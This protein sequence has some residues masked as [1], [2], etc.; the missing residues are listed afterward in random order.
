MNNDPYYED[1]N[2]FSLKKTFKKATKA[3][4]KYTPTGVVVST[5]QKVAKN[6]K[7]LVSAVKKYTPTGQVVK[8][9]SKVVNKKNITKAI[10]AGS[11]AG[12]AVGKG[13]KVVGKTAVKVAKKIGESAGMVLLAP[14]KPLKEGM[15]KVLKQ[16]GEMTSG[17]LLDVAQRFYKKVIKPQGGKNNNFDDLDDNFLEKDPLF[18]IPAYQY[19]FESCQYSN[20]DMTNSV[21]PATITLVVSAVVTYFKKAKEKREKKNKGEAVEPLTKEEA[22]AADVTDEVQKE[23]AKKEVEATPVTTGDS[24]KYIYI[25]I[26]VAVILIVVFFMRRK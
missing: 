18:S 19:D 15:K 1:E 20:G 10:K 7:K 17:S 9:A 25:G 22:I 26:A 11:K 13:A 3:V 6:P 12:K 5:V 14:L 21:D 23:L 24:K 8:L 2:N 4:K 16:K